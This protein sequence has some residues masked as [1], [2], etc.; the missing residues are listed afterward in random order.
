MKTDFPL[1]IEWSPTRV[2]VYDPG[3]G[4]SKYGAT[5]AECEP[6]RGREAVV[7]VS[8]RSAFVRQLTVPA[9][10]NGQIADVVRFQ[11]AEALPL[12]PHEV[13]FGY[14]LGA[15]I[16]G[17]G[18]LAAVGAVR[19][20]SLTRIHEE[21]RTAGLKVRAVLPIAFGSWLAARAATMTDAAVAGVDGDM[22]NVDLIKDGELFYSRSVPSADPLGEADD[23]V[24]RTFNVAEIAPL[25]IL[26]VATPEMLGNVRDPKEPL[27]YFADLRAVDHLLFTLES[28]IRQEAR[29]RRAERWKAQRAV[30]AAALAL[31][32][33][34]FGY[35]VHHRRAPAPK[36][37]GVTIAISRARKARTAAEARTAEAQRSNRVLDVAF[38]PAQTL[39]DVVQALAN[40]AS[41]N[42]WFTS[43][44]VGR[45]AP[46]NLT[47]LAMSD[48]D[49][50]R[51]FES[52]T[53]ETRFSGMKVVS[54]TKGL[55]GKTPVTQFMI[56][57]T[58]VGTLPYDRPQK[59]KRGGKKAVKVQP[60]N[61]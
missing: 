23:E 52:L 42:A 35:S 5:I 16:P 59:A 10:S 25:P 12:E 34:A 14:R 53:K 44:G 37:S 19:S 39:T 61:R 48:A 32:V 6:P 36:S 11:L 3:T 21:A 33:G 49:V 29:R 22:I 8:R 45:N 9:A 47:G 17:R 27:E 15:T 28:P 20:E 41:A 50:T 38:R 56:T 51:C 43:V 2:R 57:G 58:A 1:L 4:A 40:A 60:T 54:T 7:A 26:T 30:L 31:A 55:L 46:V 18:R 24:T 13:V